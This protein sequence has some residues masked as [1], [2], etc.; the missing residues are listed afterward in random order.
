MIAHVEPGVPLTF[1]VNE[2]LTCTKISLG[3]MDNNAYLLVPGQ[4][5]A[6]LIDAP[7]QAELLLAAL[8]GREL[9]TIVLTHRHA[10]HLGALLRLV[11]A[12]G[13]RPVCGIPDAAAIETATRVRCA[14]VWTGDEI[15]VGD[16]SLAVIG[17]VGHTPGSI[18][19]VARPGAD[20]VTHI[21]TGDSLFPGGVGRTDSP[22]AFTSLYTGVVEQL[23]AVFPDAT[24]IHPG[25]GDS[26]TLGEQRPQLA[27]WL[28]RGW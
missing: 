28:A 16:Q 25:H 22:A 18:A 13:A 3:P 12:T 11:Q 20:G 1:P 7:A 8:A 15:E 24:V 14:Q 21:F 27:D 19:L 2:R 9:A 26:T 5:P 17:L 4:G 10:D 23:F 6:V